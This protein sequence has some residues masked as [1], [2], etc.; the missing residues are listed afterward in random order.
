[1][2]GCYVKSLLR[3]HEEINDGLQSIVDYITI[4]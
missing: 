3:L 1:M 2:G 4:K